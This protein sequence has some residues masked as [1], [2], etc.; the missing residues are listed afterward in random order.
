MSPLHFALAVSVMG[1]AQTYYD[2]HKGEA[3][4]LNK[5]GYVNVPLSQFRMQE[6]AFIKDK[7]GS[8]FVQSLLWKPLPKPGEE[9]EHA[10][11]EL[12]H[13]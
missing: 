4:A 1:K 6:R 8:R 3:G 9:A 7:T 11:Y 13:L 12:A 5:D 2:E 10:V